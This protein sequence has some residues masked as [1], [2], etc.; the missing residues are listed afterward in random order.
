MIVSLD[1]AAT[2]AAPPPTVLTF[3]RCEET[4]HA[5]RQ[6][7][8]RAQCT[9]VRREVSA[10]QCSIIG[11]VDAEERLVGDAIF[12]ENDIAG[13]RETGL[14]CARKALGVFCFQVSIKI[15]R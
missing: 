14:L 10:W 1:D 4:R 12:Q 9:Y 13:K 6:V 11:D 5:I 7:F 2:S 3:G 8:A 15:V